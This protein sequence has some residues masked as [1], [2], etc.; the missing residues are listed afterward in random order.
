MRDSLITIT[1][2]V[3]ALLLLINVFFRIKTF[4][5]FKKLADLGISFGKAHLFDKDKLNQEI[6][7]KYPNHRKL[8][9]S[10]VNSMKLSLRLSTL[11]MAVLTICGGVLMYYR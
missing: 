11:C 3:F 9:L 1:I 10:H 4:R 2:V 5:T 6:I 8:I 7:S